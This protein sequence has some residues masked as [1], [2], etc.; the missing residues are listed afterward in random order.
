[1][2]IYNVKIHTMN[3]ERQVIDN[4]YV[5]FEN[6]VITKIG[7]GTPKITNSD[8]DGRGCDLY[9]GFIDAHTHLGLT[10]NGV[11]VE[12][13]DFNEESDPTASQLR[14]VDGINPMDTSFKKH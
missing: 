6:G 8:Y 9:P 13:E 7:E 1:M 4:G 12:S 2:T 3:K 11:G 10:T 14:I 5:S